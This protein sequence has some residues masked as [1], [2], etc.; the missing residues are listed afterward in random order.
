MYKDFKELIQE[1]LIEDDINAKFDVSYGSNGYVY[2][3][4]SWWL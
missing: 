2:D 1:Y 4:I 3:A